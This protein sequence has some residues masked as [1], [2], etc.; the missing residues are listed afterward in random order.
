MSRLA[1]GR[2][3]DMQML[4]ERR[5]KAT[6]HTWEWTKVQL[7]IDDLIEEGKC[8]YIYHQRERLVKAARASDNDEV[9]N[10]SEQIDKH[11]KYHHRRRYLRQW[12]TRG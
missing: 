11:M 6:P 9:V 7:K 10:I 8:D 4:L 3:H 12:I 2:T 1:P 5:D